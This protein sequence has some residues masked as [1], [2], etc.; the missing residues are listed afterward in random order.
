MGMGRPTIYAPKLAVEIC[1]NLAAGVSMRK[2]CLIGKMPAQTT[3][4]RWLRSNEDFR[5]QYTQARQW[6]ADT[7]F[8]ECLDIA[9]D[10][11]CDVMRARLRVDTRKWM[12]GKLNLK[13]YG[14]KPDDRDPSDNE[15]TMTWRGRQP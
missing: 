13:K 9:D 11:E 6:Q 4:Y 10:E 7:L 5:Q 15:M 8:D 12:A 14:D 1:D 2:I 3:I